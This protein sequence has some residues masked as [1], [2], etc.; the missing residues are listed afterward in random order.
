MTKNFLEKIRGENLFLLAATGACGVL[1]IFSPGLAK[2]A[3]TEFFSICVKIIPSFILVF[4]LMFAFNLFSDSEK[5]K[6]MIGKKAGAKGWLWAIAGGIAS[7][8]PIYMWYPLLADLKEKGTKDG[9]IASFLY[10]RAV[11]LPLLP[12]MIFYFG[13]ALTIII[14]FYIIVFSAINGF[15]VEK[16]IKNK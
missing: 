16:I 10:S 6:K 12:V 7:S 9:L 14:N 8:G 2:N 4:A 15:L 11:K 1:A 5:I 3:A 13:A